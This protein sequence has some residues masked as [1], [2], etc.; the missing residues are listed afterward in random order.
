MQNLPI[1]GT[2]LCGQVAY[3]VEQP[4][5]FFQYCHCS[6]CRKATGSAHAANAFVKIKQFRWTRGEDLVRRFELPDAR[7]FCTSFCSVCGSYLPWLSRTGRYVLL[8][9]GTLDEDPGVTPTRNIHWAS[10]APWYVDVPDLPLHDA[11][12]R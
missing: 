3:E 9:A 4:F 5:I 11:E 2:C 1:S 12:P 10:R 8:P 7:Y 6:R